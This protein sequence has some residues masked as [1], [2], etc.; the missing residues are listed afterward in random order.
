MS[1][2]P[3]AWKLARLDELCEWISGGTPRRS[4][5]SYF[6][7]EFPW[8]TISDLNDGVVFR[9]AESLT[10]A[11]I[12]NSAA[13]LVPEG[14]VLVALY[15][16]IGKLGITKRPST[17]NQAI[18]CALPDEQ[19]FDPLYLFHYLRSKRYELS[20]LGTG[21]TQK[22]IYLGDIKAFVIPV[23]PRAE[24]TRIVAKLEEL[25]SDLDAGVEELKAAQKKLQQY[26]QSLLK[27]AVEGELTAPWR[28]AKRK[29]GTLTETGLQLLQRVL[30]ERRARWEATQLAKFEE[31]GKVPP[32]DWR[33]KYPEPVQPDTTNL[34]VL[35]EGWV[36][37]SLDMLGEIVSGV[38]KGT[39]RGGSVLVREVPYLRVANV[40]RGYLDLSEVKTIFATERDIEELTLKS[41]DVLF[42][43]GGDRDKLGRGWVWRDELVQC[44]HQNHVF[45]MRPYL[46]DLLPELISH[47][48]NTFGKLWF[49]NAG[50]QTTNLASINM[51]NLRRFPVPVAPATEQQEALVQIQAQLESLD[52]QQQVTDLAMK[53]S[54]AQRQ[55]ILRAAFTGQ[56]VQQDPDDEPVDG[57]LERVLAERAERAKQPKARKT[58]QKKE[59]A[60][61]MS[62][63]ID[64][65]A[66]TGDWLPA[67]EAF[68]RCGVA[69]GALT[70]QIE[71]LFAELRALDKA[72]RLAIEPVVDAQGRKL[73][74]NLK[75]LAD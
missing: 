18:A 43:E 22:N 69:D 46:P 62:R 4:E 53:Q 11:G 55:N 57:L 25:L 34:P 59:I 64:V 9:T 44:I 45:R 52:R 41:G 42:N 63:L 51:T 1:E 60:T 40:Q 71:V 73:Y 32:K 16:S 3:K 19:A 10:K 48:G 30:A 15:G 21:I 31:Q 66:K 2:L 74:D 20:L 23:A 12:L 47:H 58:K 50:K 61:V 39:K 70:D 29:L 54:G 67:Q 56:L 8:I 27:A 75:L 33:M 65:L 35:P 37:A 28:Q 72:G 68:R 17:T 38:A 24:Q 36:W 13:K 49:Q 26:R 14:T 5:P 7:G 6:G